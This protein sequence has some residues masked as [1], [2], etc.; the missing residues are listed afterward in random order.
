MLLSRAIGCKAGES[1]SRALLSG[2]SIHVRLLS[3]E[4][5]LA[6]PPSAESNQRHSSSS[7]SRWKSRQNKDRYVINAKVQDL[8]SRAAFKLL[9]VCINEE[10]LDAYYYLHCAAQR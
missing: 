1:Y 6:L 5:A 8:K 2:Q 7:S 3:L 9:E 4:F 10:F